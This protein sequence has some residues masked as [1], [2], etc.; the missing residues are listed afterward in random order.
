V[1][2]LTSEKRRKRRGRVYSSNTRSAHEGENL[3]LREEK[4]KRRGEGAQIFYPIL[5]TAKKGRKEREK[6]KIPSGRTLRLLVGEKEP[7]EKEG[8]KRFPPVFS[9]EEGVKEV[10]RLLFKKRRDFEGKK[11]RRRGP[12]GAQKKIGPKKEEK[13]LQLLL[14]HRIRGRGEGHGREGETTSREKEHVPNPS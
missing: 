8:K 7:E 5:I 3:D 12:K 1:R 13:I 4:K 14:L 10:G 11:S 2:P 6:E 9:R